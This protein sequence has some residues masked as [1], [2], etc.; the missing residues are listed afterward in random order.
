MG[1]SVAFCKAG[2]EEEEGK[3]ELRN[4]WMA[5]NCSIYMALLVVECAS[6]AAQ[7]LFQEHADAEITHS[8]AE[9]IF[10]ISRPGNR[11]PAT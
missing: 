4:Y 10:H 3:G 8:I 1:L 7:D 11:N 5:F 6:L 9:I 2:K